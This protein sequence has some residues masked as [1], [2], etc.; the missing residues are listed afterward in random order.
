M[1]RSRSGMLL[2]C[3]FVSWVGSGWLAGCSGRLVECQ[4]LLGAAAV[5]LVLGW[6]VVVDS[7]WLRA[8]H[9]RCIAG[10]HMPPTMVHYC[11]DDARH[12]LTAAPDRT[13]R[14]VST[15]AD[16]QNREMSQ[17][18]GLVR[19]SKAL[20][21]ELA[22]LKLQ[23]VSLPHRTASTA[24][25]HRVTAQRHCTASPHCVN[26]ASPHY[27]YPSPS[28]LQDFS[29]SFSDS[30]SALLHCAPCFGVLNAPVLPQCYSLNALLRTLRS[31]L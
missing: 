23:P 4:W 21:V 14:F 5:L 17:G 9:S 8:A 29:C 3:S 13:L 16:H 10:H 27:P 31:G 11:G 24:S 7:S 1:L 25:L 2:G 28:A 6:L 12:L 26:T 18:A 19:D 15:I 20:G 22:D 30:L